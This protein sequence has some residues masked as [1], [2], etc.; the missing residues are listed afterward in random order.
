MSLLKNLQ[1]S[2]TVYSDNQAFCIGDKFYTYGEL[3]EEVKVILNGI[4]DQGITDS[5][6]AVVGTDELSTYA[7]LLAIWF[8]GNAYIPLGLH[9]PLER[10]KSILKEAGTNLIIAS[11]LSNAGEY[12]DFKIL[13]PAILDRSKSGEFSVDDKNERLA[14]MLFTSGSTGVPKGVPITVGNLE[15][16]VKNFEEAGI[17]VR[18]DDRCLQMFEL[19]FDVSI[20]SFLVPLLHGACVY[21]VSSEGIRSL[22]VLRII[23]Q[24]KLTII[25]MV[26]SVINLGKGYL[27]SLRFDHVRISILTGEA[28]MITLL[29]LWRP[30]VRNADLYN[31]YGP[32]ETTIYCSYYKCDLNNPKEYNGMLAIGKPMGAVS[33]VLLNE[34][35]E[36]AALNEKA[37]LMIG[38]SQLTRGYLN[39]KEKN[40]QSFVKFASGNQTEIFY[41]SGDMA[42][43]DEDGDIFYCGRFDNQVKIQGFRVELSEIESVVRIKFNIVSFAIACANKNGLIELFVVTDQKLD[44]HDVIGSLKA[45]LPAYMIP[46]RVI[47]IENLP[48]TTSGK[49]DRS[50][51]K[52]MIENGHI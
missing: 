26:P 15:E 45:S 31:F 22:Q 50:K 5:T 39:N 11:N 2:L 48:I 47:E 29:N 43:K 1:R 19:T 23:N 38:G 41:K 37:E 6:I 4:H 16:F 40:D 14:Y 10:N 35:G 17:H 3:A 32:T 13:N 20:S 49:V 52:A 30:C 44:G 18:A 28:T 51:L 8:S 46:S 27:K 24:Y 21:T 25:Q 33:L 42:Y 34:K 7:S 9:N 36:I 12:A